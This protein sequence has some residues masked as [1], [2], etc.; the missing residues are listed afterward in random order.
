MVELDGYAT[1]F[2]ALSEPL[3]LRLLGMLPARD[4]KRTFCV[5]ELA[6][7]LGISQPCLSHHLN[8]LKSA[9]LVGFKKDGCSAFYYVDREQVVARLDEFQ[10]QMR[11]S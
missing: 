8:V 7:R 10:E 9:G 1:V 11:T 3:R 2:K 4:E 6:E 5:C